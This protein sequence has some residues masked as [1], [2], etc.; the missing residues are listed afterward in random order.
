MMIRT[1]ARLTVSIGLVLLLLAARAANGADQNAVQARWIQAQLNEWRIGLDL[2]PLA[3]NATLE[4]LAIS[5][6]EYVLSLSQWPQNVHA[7]RSGEGPRIRA[8]WD[9]YQWPTY[10]AGDQIVVGEITWLGTREDAISFW[11]GSSIHRQTAT[12]PYYREVGIAAIPGGR[13]FLFVAVLGARPNV[14]PALADPYDDIV[15]LSAET[16]NRGTGNSWIR[17]VTQVRLFDSDGR[18]I[19]D[20]WMPWQ[21]KV[22][23][24]ENAG[25]NLYVLYSDGQREVM[26]AV[27]LLER[28]TPLPEY[29]DAWQPSVTGV[30]T[31]VLPTSTPTPVPIP[32]IHIVYD[33][34]SLT[35]YNSSPA[36]ANVTGLQLVSGGEHIQAVAE[37]NDGYIR[38]SL[39]ALPS[40]NCLHITRIGSRAG[41][42]PSQCSYSSTTTLL[43]T[44]LFWTS[45]DFQVR[46]GDT[47]I[48]E[49]RQ[50]EGACE[51][52]L[53]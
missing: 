41:T 12:N 22:P 42:P 13:G 3:Y 47:L 7:G 11:H 46:Q 16:Y 31:A 27:S 26:D 9:P 33:S 37:L 15:Y 45:G 8:R 24:P 4:A 5:Q 44:Q 25:D 48:A 21:A 6:A 39:R 17:Q 20:G 28:D 34:R 32:H 36:P 40:Y 30:P 49:C 38:G 35:L 19:S 53:P 1:L 52:D 43:A 50:D 18:P 2:G 14:L 29:A 10:G 23:I 51:F